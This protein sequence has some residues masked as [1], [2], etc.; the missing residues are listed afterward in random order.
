MNIEGSVIKIMTKMWLFSV[1]IWKFA[2]WSNIRISVVKLSTY[3]TFLSIL[4]KQVDIAVK[5][6]K[7]G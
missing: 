7:E 1:N 2:V 3:R 4:F 5:M 6:F